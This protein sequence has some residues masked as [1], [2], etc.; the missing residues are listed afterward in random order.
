MKKTKIL[1]TLIALLSLT[2]CAVPQPTVE[3]ANPNANTENESQEDVPAKTLLLCAR[4][5]HINMF[6]DLIDY[7]ELVNDVDVSY[8]VLSDDI[9]ER[10]MQITRI[11]TEILAGSGPDIF[12]LDSVIPQASDPI[13]LFENV[14]KQIESGIFYNLDTLIEED[15]DFDLSKY[16]EIVVNAGRSDDGLFVFPLNYTFPAITTNESTDVLGYSLNDISGIENDIL[17]SEMTSLAYVYFPNTFASF[18]DYKNEKLLVSKDNILE[19]SK[20]VTELRN[21]VVG[22]N[23]NSTETTGIIGGIQ[24]SLE[25]VIEDQ[26]IVALYNDNS[27]ISAKINLYTAINA[28]TDMSE[29]CFDLMKIFLSDEI[30]TGDQLKHGEKYYGTFYSNSIY[31]LPVNDYVF[32]DSLRYNYYGISDAIINDVT[33][34]KNQIDNVSFNCNIDREIFGITFFENDIEQS[35]QTIQSIVL[36]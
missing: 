34:M 7:Y 24:D 14:N 23:E 31:G 8:D 15:D 6:D 5:A 10:E 11:Q 26:S 35:Y 3:T 13:S 17:R 36:E 32:E 20:T 2:A 16:N 28:T 33:D 30:Q 1:A 25:F 21:S 29:E 22:L 4:E 12:I 9:T 19:S 18:A 27:G